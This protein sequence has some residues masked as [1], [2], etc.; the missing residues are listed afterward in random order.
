MLRQLGTTDLKV[1]PFCLG[2]NV[3]GWTVDQDSAFEIL[4]AFTDA[5][6]NF[7]DTSDVYWKFK[8]GNRGGESETIIGQWMRRRGNRDRMVVSTKIGAFDGLVGGLTP[9]KIQAHAEDSM[10]RLGVDC[11]DL[12]YAHTDDPATPLEDTLGAFDDLVR[13][14][15]VRY[16]AASRYE[17][18]RLQAALEVAAD[19]NWA[20]YCATQNLYS[21]VER[22]YET[23]QR[24]LVEANQ[25]GMMPYYAL[26]AGFLTGKYRPGVAVDSVR[27]KG[28]RPSG[29]ES[30]LDERGIRL[31]DVLD[32][33]AA[34]HGTTVAAVSLAWLTAQPTV[35]APIAS[36]RSVDQ[37]AGLLPSTHIRLSSDDLRR[38]DEA[39]DER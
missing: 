29:A 12:L 5:G 21:L 37:L 28:P 34:T 39:S 8:E 15:K 33:L 1:F 14:G 38:L 26:G 20:P 35:T 25:L 30:Y 19:Y 23:A 7:F 22:G 10:R 36:A 27:A 3:F 11:I 2:C 18:R 31:L 17:A 6:G 32:D 16:I 4:D 9:A 24:P 13:S